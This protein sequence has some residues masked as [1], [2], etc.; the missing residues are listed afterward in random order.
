MATPASFGSVVPLWLDGKEQVTVT[1]YDVVSPRTNK[2]LYKSSAATVEDAEKAIRGAEAALP[3]WSATKPS[4][5][6]DI[7]LR[8]ADEIAKR[9]DELFKIVSYETGASNSM[10]DFEINLAIEACKSTAGLIAAVRGQI[11]TVSDE[12][13]SAIIVREPYGVVLSI[14]PWNAP[15]VLGFRSVLGPLAMGNTVVLKGAEASPGVFWA[16][17]SMLHDAGLPAGCLNTI[18]HRP[19]DAAA[20]T[21][22]IIASPAV[23]KINF[24]GSTNIGAV[25][26]TQ[27]AKLLKPVL[28]ELGGKAPTIV[29][30]DA[31][32]EVAALGCTLGAFLHSGQICMSTERVI[33]HKSI[34]SKLGEAMRAVSDQIFGGPEGLILVNEASVKKNKAL[35]DDAIAKGAKITYNDGSFT[36]DKPTTMKPVII[37]D[38]DKNM[39][40]YYTESF[41]P[42]VSIYSVESD[43]EA[44]KLANDTEYGLSSAVFTEDLRRGLRIAK[45]IQSGAVHIN[46]MSIHD[47][48]ALPHGGTKKSGYGRFNSIEGLEE[49]VH[50]KVIT[51][52]D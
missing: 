10:F 12:G 21:S 26:A 37:E 27:A 31:D 2:Q 22:H 47:E 36:T 52:M 33:A 51:W 11:P 16:I 23:K 40:V 1:T 24:T 4:V 28:L 13:Q 15:Y 18:I 44:I 42:T 41:G 43:E 7:L 46:S 17:S 3:A 5:R 49:W 20:V 38:V 34:A 50:T 48:S 45:Q 35:I 9:R 39:D 19:Q 6:R 32:L 29:C 14:A 30:Q 8:A 25:I